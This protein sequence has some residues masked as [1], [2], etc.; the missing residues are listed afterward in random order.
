MY[1]TARSG[2]G[3]LATRCRLV[4]QPAAPVSRDGEFDRHVLGLQ[5]LHEV[6]IVGRDVDLLLLPQRGEGAEVGADRADIRQQFAQRLEGRLEVGL[7]A[8]LDAVEFGQEG[9]AELAVER[10]EADA[11]L[12]FR[13]P[14]IVPALRRR[15]DLLRIIADADHLHGDLRAPFV[16]EFRDQVLE[17]RRLGRRIFDDQ[18]FLD[19]I[20]HLRRV[21]ERDVERRLVALGRGQARDLIGAEHDRLRHRGAGRRLEGRRDDVAVGLVPGAG[22][23]RGHQRLRL[24]ADDRRHGE[25]GAE[26]GGAADQGPAVKTIV[27]CAAPSLWCQDAGKTWQASGEVGATCTWSP[28]CRMVSGPRAAR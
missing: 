8:A 19:G 26:R 17:V 22:E 15:L 18:P 21:E 23:G 20:E 14:Q 28:V 6:E 3:A 12:V 24:R 9:D 25:A 16:L 1:F 5:R 13:I 27:S 4:S 10:G 7:A 2:S 11:A